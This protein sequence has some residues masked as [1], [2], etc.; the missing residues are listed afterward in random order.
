MPTERPGVVKWILPP[1]LLALF[2][3]SL[4]W[5]ADR[6]AAPAPVDGC[7]RCHGDVRGLEASHAALGCAACHLG[8]RAARDETAAH[9]GLVL[10]PGNDAD[11]DRTCGTAGCHP[12]MPPRMRNSIMSTMNGVVSVDRWVFGEQ[13]TPTARTPIASLGTSSPADLHLRNLCASCHVTAQKRQWGPIGEQ[14]RGGGCNACHLRYPAEALGQL[15]AGV[16]R[17][18]HPQLRAR[19]TRD[20]CFGCHSRSGRV[21][22]SYEGWRESD[23]GGARTLADGRELAPALPDVHFERGLECVD[24]HV[25]WEVMGEGSYAL[26]REDQAQVACADCHLTGAAKTLTF[27]EADPEAQKLTRLTGGDSSPARRF[28]TV[29]RTGRAFPGTRALPD[30]GL[31]LEPAGPRP[32]RRLAPIAAP[33]GG[34]GAHA[35]LSCGACHDAWAPQ[36]TGCH[37][38]F[39]A[40]EVMFDL[41]D[42]DERQGRFHEAPGPRLAAPP[43]LGVRELRVDGGVQRRV[44]EFTPGMVLT[45]ARTA[46]EQA[47]PRFRRLYAAG[48]P[49]TVRREVRDCASCHASPLALGYGRGRLE[50]VVRGRAGEWRFTPS[51]PASAADGLPGDAWIGFLREPGAATTTREDTRPFTLAEQRRILTVGACLTCHPPASAPMREALRDP[52]RA[53]GQISPRCATPRWP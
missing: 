9:A 6:R 5:L 7:V 35:A 22:L 47:A 12:E 24:C 3:S 18:T 51:T 36:C 17:T 37:T 1:V 44:E 16:H 41:L 48:F 33:C 19:P 45:L 50:Y 26:H 15:D 49:H 27:A 46:A 34:D 25:S 8:D 38:R 42:G 21:S 28:L 14:S 39:D 31:E 23:D 30:G 4:A 52:T 29:G 53:L 43:A 32:A 11:V 13:P 40:T 20:H 10:I 2:M